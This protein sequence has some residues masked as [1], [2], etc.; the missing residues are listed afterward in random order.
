MTNLLLDDCQGYSV[1][2]IIVSPAL[3]LQVLRHLPLN[4]KE[5]FVV[6]LHERMT[7]ADLKNIILQRKNVPLNEQFLYIENNQ[8]LL[9]DSLTIRSIYNDNLVIQLFPKAYD[10]K[11]RI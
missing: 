7:V 5:Y 6:E 1:N 3:S 2:D 8:I 4:R 10:L 11:S 9:K